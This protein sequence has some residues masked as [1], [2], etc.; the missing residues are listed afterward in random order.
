L[1][2]L[3]VVPLVLQ[4]AF[5]QDVELKG[6]KFG[7]GCIG[8]LSTYGRGLGTC[9]VAGAKNRI[10]C[11]NGK[12]IERSAEWPNGLFVLRAICDLNQAP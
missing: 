1:V 10:W 3:V 6:V 12:V 5:A 9:P 4:A 8:P 2:G 11:P 7:D